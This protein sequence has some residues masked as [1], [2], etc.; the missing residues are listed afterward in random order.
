MTRFGIPAAAWD[1]RVATVRRAGRIDAL[2]VQADVV[3]P[4]EDLMSALVAAE[5][6]GD[7]DEQNRVL[8]LMTRRARARRAAAKAAA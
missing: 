4:E 2:T 5:E 3:A 1:V 7:V 6:S 8:G